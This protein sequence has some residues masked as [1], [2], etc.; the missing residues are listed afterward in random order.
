MISIDIVNDVIENP[1]KVI[2]LRENEIEDCLNHVIP[3]LHRE[4]TL[5]ELTGKIAFVGDTHGDFETTKSIIKKFFEYDHLVFLGDYIDRE[6]TKWGSIY[7]MTYL[8]FL[9]YRYPKKIILLKGNH[10]SNNII[11]CYPY[12]FEQEIIQRYGSSILHDKFEEVF[13][14]MP[15][16]SLV[17]NVYAAHGG[18]L[19]GISLDE[20]KRI[21][22]N[23]YTAIE[24][25]VWSDPSISPTKRGIGVPFNKEELAYFLSD[26]GAKVFIRGHD[27]R[28][29]GTSIFGDRCLTIFSSRLYKE[30]GNE[31][32]LVAKT[33][34]EISCINDIG[35]EDFSTGKWINYKIAKK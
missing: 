24:S 30:M 32:I 8:L 29:L 33:E 15:L 10:E 5:I 27:Y 4:N 22:K 25:I 6:P 1:N 2:H 19:K 11:P 21:R 16:M 31:G 12:E 35:L 7:N 20:L 18:I 28:T 26:I 17:N 3:I 13:S 23:D 34:K 9:K 14:E